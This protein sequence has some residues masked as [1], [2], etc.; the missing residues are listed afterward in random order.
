LGILKWVSW[1]LKSL[2]TDPDVALNEG[3]LGR[4]DNC[5]GRER[6]Q[7]QE[8]ITREACAEESKPFSTC[9]NQGAGRLTSHRS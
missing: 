6:C 8:R 2:K 3:T 5:G 1:H 9:R 4:A 7:S